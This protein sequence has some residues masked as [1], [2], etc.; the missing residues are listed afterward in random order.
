MRSAAIKAQLHLLAQ[1]LPEFHAPQPHP[2]DHATKLPD[3]LAVTPVSTDNTPVEGPT[4]PNTTQPIPTAALTN[5]AAS[6][7][8][9]VS[10][11][12]LL[13]PKLIPPSSRSLSST[14]VSDNTNNTAAECLHPMSYS[15]PRNV[16]PP[17]SP[18]LPLCPVPTSAA[19]KKTTPQKIHTW[20]RSYLH[21]YPS[22]NP[23][24]PTCG[25]SSKIM[26]IS[27]ILTSLK[28]ISFPQSTTIHA[29]SLPGN[30]T[31]VHNPG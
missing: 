11:A 26:P 23:T 20:F 30:P 15:G 2:D 1:T 28:H 16:L 13:A 25:N 31:Q 5:L 9:T 19:T 6:P 14:S 4:T 18:P 24:D 21:Q 12:A 17:P 3:Q 10:S 27:P 8:T 22:Q 29:L 7:D